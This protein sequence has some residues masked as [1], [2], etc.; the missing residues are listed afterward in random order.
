MHNSREKDKKKKEKHGGMPQQDETGRC[1]YRVRCADCS[2][3]NVLGDMVG[4]RYGV[5]LVL[6]NWSTT[7][8]CHNVQTCRVSR[9]GCKSVIGKAKS[10][11]YGWGKP[12]LSTRYKRTRGSPGMG[13]DVDCE[14][15]RLC[16]GAPSAQPISTMARVDV[17]LLRRYNSFQAT[18]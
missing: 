1:N 4:G 13:R 9:Y 7:V 5:H 17:Q 10:N 8:P 15:R 14:I 2:S 6:F 12:I 3:Y 18:T 11:E 16:L